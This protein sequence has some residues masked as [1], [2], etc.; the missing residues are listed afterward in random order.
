MSAIGKANED[1]IHSRDLNEVCVG[2]VAVRVRLSHFRKV[3]K[4]WDGGKS[5]RLEAGVPYCAGN[6]PILFAGSGLSCLS[7]FRHFRVDDSLQSA[8]KR[9]PHIHISRLGETGSK[10]PATIY[11]NGGIYRVGKDGSSQLVRTAP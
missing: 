3:G 2:F 6:G 10:A 5:D 8:A 11:L 1:S 4:T 7:D 9:E